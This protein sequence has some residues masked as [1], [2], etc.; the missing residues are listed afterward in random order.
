MI[1]AARRAAVDALRDIDE[2]PLDLGEAIA[3]ARQG[4]ADER[5]RALLL[6]IVTGTLRMRA[7]LD[8]QIAQRTNRPLHKLDAAVLRIL[9]AAAFQLMHLS[10]LPASAVINDSVELTRRAGKSSAAGFV[11]AVL[12]KLSRE[13]DV[14]QWPDDIAVI[15][16][17]PRWLIDRWVARH[18]LNATELWLQFNNRPAA[19]CLA[20]NSTLSTRDEVAR[21]LAAGGVI[22]EPTRRARHGLVVIE[23]HPFAHP[24]FTEGRCIVQD[25]ASQLIA[26]LVVAAC[27]A[28][29]F[30]EGREAATILDLCASPGGKTLHLSSAV[31]VRG[32]VVASDVRPRRV[33][34]LRR[35]VD[36]CK[37]ANARVVHVPADGP[38]PFQD[39]SFDAILIDAPCSGLGTVRRDPDIKWKRSAA[40]L[41]RFA[42]DQRR[43]LER[44]APLVRPGGCMVYSTC[45]SEPEENED[46]VDAFVRAHG[47]YRL[48]RTHQTLPFRDGLEAFFGAVLRRVE[49]SA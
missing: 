38:L 23:G 22:T 44:A 4:L 45:S 13:R 18:G 15:H 6:E 26:E 10:R 39:D 21:E 30:G 17:H 37:L 49:S 5:D 28:E 9:R 3:R 24:A 20:V 7:A 47:G 36:R 1:G 16:S 29:A 34:M 14:L 33:R 48:E 27:L 11:N 42:S 19:L 35:T 40:D 2:I 43:L 46:V 31:G 41:P 25:E 8:Y 32:L 12:R